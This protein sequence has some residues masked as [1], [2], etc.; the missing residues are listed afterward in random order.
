ME[1]LEYTEALEK[2][3][4]HIQKGTNYDEAYA[5][6]LAT[7]N[8]HHDLGETNRMS[9]VLAIKAIEDTEML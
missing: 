6:M 1:D 5:L 4:K 8:D 9:A 7:F 3:V 2:L